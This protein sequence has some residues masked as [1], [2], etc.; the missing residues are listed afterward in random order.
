LLNTSLL[1]IEWYSDLFIAKPG[2]NLILWFQSLWNQNKPQH[3]YC[4]HSTLWII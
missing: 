2:P 4:L 1:S 3:D